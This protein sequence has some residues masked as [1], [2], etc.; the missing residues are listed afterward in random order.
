SLWTILLV[1]GLISTAAATTYWIDGSKSGGAGCGGS[2]ANACKS[3]HDLVSNNGAIK[4]NTSAD[5]VNVVAGTYHGNGSGKCWEIGT[6]A[7]TAGG[8]LSIQ[9]TDTNGN[10]SPGRCT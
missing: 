5:T 1:H 10:Y 8:E 7:R 6:A 9:C 4:T 2:Q 3:W